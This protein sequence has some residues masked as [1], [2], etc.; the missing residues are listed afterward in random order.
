MIWHIILFEIHSFGFDTVS[1]KDDFA[2]KW[3]TAKQPSRELTKFL[4][5]LISPLKK[6]IPLGR[7]FKLPVDKLSKILIVKFFFPTLFLRI[8]QNWKIWNEKS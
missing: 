6:F 3:N 4:G 7:F 2:A 1:C 5:F 8:N